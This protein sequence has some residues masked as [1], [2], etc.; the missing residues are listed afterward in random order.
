VTGGDRAGDG[1]HDLV[2]GPG[3]SV[4]AGDLEWRFS[5]A[6]GP[7]GQHQNTS[8]T[9]AEVVVDLSSAGGLPDWARVRLIDALGPVVSASAGD[10]RS[11][12]RNRDLARARLS[13]KLAAALEVPTPRR[14]TRLP[15]G[16]RRR[17]I[18]AKR[19]RSDVKRA[20]RPPPA[21][22]D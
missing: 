22:T 19:R 8:N 11:Q 9:R 1:R 14:P 17:R 5:T 18:E 6:G 20:R 12:G 4:R 15:P 16:A 10:S 3:L 2:L 21:D 7:G 13:A